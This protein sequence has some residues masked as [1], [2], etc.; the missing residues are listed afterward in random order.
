MV[1]GELFLIVGSFEFTYQVVKC[2]NLKKRNF[3]YVLFLERN[4]GKLV[5]E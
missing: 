1:V 3:A 4:G 2:Y 5:V